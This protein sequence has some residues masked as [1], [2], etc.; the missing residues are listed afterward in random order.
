[1]LRS[2]KNV[3]ARER[4]ALASD[5]CPAHCQSGVVIEPSFLSSSSRGPSYPDLG[6]EKGEDHELV[7]TVSSHGCCLPLQVPCAVP[8]D[9]A[10][11]SLWEPSRQLQVQMQHW[12]W[13]GEWGMGFSSSVMFFKYFKSIFQECGG[14]RKEGVG[15]KLYGFCRVQGINAAMLTSRRVCYVLQ[16]S[17]WEGFWHF[18]FLI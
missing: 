13:G 4:N 18:V 14:L 2:K 10:N 7:M 17:T 3:L 15:R 1:M 11:L 6:S 16:D 5:T 12:Q 9:L 8:V